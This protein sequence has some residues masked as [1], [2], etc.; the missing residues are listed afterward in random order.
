MGSSCGRDAWGGGRSK[1]LQQRVELLEAENETLQKQVVSDAHEVPGEDLITQLLK[2][3]GARYPP[4]QRT[5][6]RRPVLLC[7]QPP[8]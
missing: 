3:S 4:T 8:T 5:P 2:P 6:R 7:V 1:A